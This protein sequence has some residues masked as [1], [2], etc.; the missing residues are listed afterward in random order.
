MLGGPHFDNCL[1]SIGRFR[2]PGAHGLPG[3]K[4]RF[5]W[6]RVFGAKFLVSRSNLGSKKMLENCRYYMMP[7]V[8]LHIHMIYHVYLLFIY[9]YLYLFIFIYS[10]ICLSIYLSVCLTIYLSLSISI[11]LF[12]IC[13][14]IYIYIT[15]YPMIK[16]SQRER[17]QTLTS[18]LYLFL[19]NTSPASRS[20]S[21][22]TRVHG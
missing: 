12:I 11:Y 20:S 6:S 14:F 10:F 1:G 4:S 19:S 21:S 5:S 8:I 9:I 22:R 18:E 16:E 15:S 3:F 13:L 7:S 17:I 2:Q